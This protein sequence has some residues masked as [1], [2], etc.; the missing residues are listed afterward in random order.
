VLRTLGELGA[1]YSEAVEML[2]QADSCQS[3]S[4]PVLVDQLPQA[5]PV[6]ELARAGARDPELLQ[7]DKEIL[8]ARP[9][10]GDTPTLYQKD[11]LG[12]SAE[13]EAGE[14]AVLHDRQP[15]S[16]R[17]GGAGSKSVE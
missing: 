4:C 11:A 5:M 6:Q 16:G 7:M 1:T 14:E 8:S 13:T 3:V 17:A 10:F 2:R 15:R 9:D 12:T